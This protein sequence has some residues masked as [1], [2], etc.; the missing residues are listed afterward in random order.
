MWNEFLIITVEGNENDGLRET[1]TP[2]SL[3]AVWETP[4]AARALRPSD[5]DGH[6]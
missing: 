2:G 1:H 6:R 4:V 5:T 3:V